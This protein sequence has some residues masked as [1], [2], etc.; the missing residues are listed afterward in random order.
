MGIITLHCSYFSI[1]KEVIFV[2][3]V[4]NSEASW[5]WKIN[6]L[7][8][9]VFFT[10][11]LS[12]GIGSTVLN[13]IARDHSCKESLTLHLNDLGMYFDCGKTK[14][15]LWEVY[16]VSQYEEEGG[17][18]TITSIWCVTAPHHSCS[19]PQTPLASGCLVL[20][21]NSKFISFLK[22]LST[23]VCQPSCLP[24]DH[25]WFIWTWCDTVPLVIFLW[26]YTSSQYF[27]S[28]WR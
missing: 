9:S 17:R 8:T 5:K 4:C 27:K 6:T 16:S 13:N 26:A 12:G 24:H 25:S 15:K 21:S 23:V 7:G 3:S 28:S 18:K 10:E 2:S 19:L 22:P 11:M 20:P 14:I 1:L